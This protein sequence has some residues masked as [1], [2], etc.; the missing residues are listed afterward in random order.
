MTLMPKIRFS[1]FVLLASIVTSL[2]AAPASPEGLF[3]TAVKAR[4]AGDFPTALSNF[5]AALTFEP[6]NLHYGS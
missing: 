4:G 2:T 5:E 6:D 1:N 3:Q